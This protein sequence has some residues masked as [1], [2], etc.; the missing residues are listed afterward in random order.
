MNTL[1]CGCVSDWTVSLAGEG[2]YSYVV[3][4]VTFQIIK[5]ITFRLR[6]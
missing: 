6:R 5:C 1:T 3:C 2:S 4:G